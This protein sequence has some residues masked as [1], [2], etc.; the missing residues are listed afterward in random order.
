MNR[1][2]KAVSLLLG[3]F[4]CLAFLAWSFGVRI[5]TT[6][7]V[8][9]GMY[10]T[11]D[12]PV[13]YGSYV[14]FCPPDNEIFLEARNRGYFSHGFCPGNYGQLMKKVFATGNDVISVTDQGVTVN[15]LLVPLSKPLP[16]D[17]ANRPM[18]RYR[19]VNYSLMDNEVLLMSDITEYSFDARY[20]GP[21]DIKQISSVVRPIITW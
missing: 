7:S 17:K 21:I 15:E 5:N 19:V 14:T 1:I 8:P 4:L 18:P 6:V 2:L 16:A 3:A 11:T 13:S 20:F 9:L 12:E 10:F